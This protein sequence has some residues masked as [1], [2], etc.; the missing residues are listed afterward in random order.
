MA[1]CLRLWFK[2]LDAYN[3]YVPRN[4]TSFF[5]FFFNSLEDLLTFMDVNAFTQE[6][7]CKLY[8]VLN[9][10]SISINMAT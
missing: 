7:I 3:V 10:S 1:L 9:L 4:Y 2:S 6:I 5:F 8:N